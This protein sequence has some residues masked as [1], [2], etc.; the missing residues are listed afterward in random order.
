MRIVISPF[1]EIAKYDGILLRVSAIIV[2]TALLGTNPSGAFPTSKVWF[3][4]AI[5]D[6]VLPNTTVTIPPLFLNDIRIFYLC[7]CLFEYEPF[8]G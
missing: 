3:T 5:S 6:V 1:E 8:S 2:Y 7:I 4:N